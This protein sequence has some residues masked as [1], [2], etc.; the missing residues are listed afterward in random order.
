MLLRPTP[1]FRGSIESPRRHVV[2]FHHQYE[3]RFTAQETPR[4]GTIIYAKLGDTTGK[5][6]ATYLLSEPHSSITGKASHTIFE[7]VRVPSVTP[8][9]SRS[10]RHAAYVNMNDCNFGQ[11]KLA[12]ESPSLL[13]MTFPAS[14]SHPQ[15]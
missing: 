6:K 10:Q 3:I 9:N 11:P 1:C 12:M 4:N 2:D 8:Q 15:F 7:I 14:G 5:K 13:S